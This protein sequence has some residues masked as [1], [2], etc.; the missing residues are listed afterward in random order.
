[1]AT[2][3]P[4]DVEL[5]PLDGEARTV[6]EWTTTFHLVLVVLDPFTHES[7]WVLKPARRILQ[8]FAE[9]DCRV[10]WLV[11]GTPAQTRQ[12][13]GPLATDFLTFADPDRTAIKA[14]ELEA[15]PAFV[16]LNMDHVVEAEAEGWDP[17]EWKEVAQNLATRMSWLAPTIPQPR[18]PAPFTGTPV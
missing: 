6:S 4:D 2:Q 15:L 12:F 16:H 18:D 17:T 13:L 9:A 11:G 10:G 5:A 14:M 1:M 3:V 7:A 8:N